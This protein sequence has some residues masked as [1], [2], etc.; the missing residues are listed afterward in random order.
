M[1]IFECTV[2]G[3]LARW[4]DGRFFPREHGHYSLAERLLA[5]G[6]IPQL[7]RNGYNAVM[8]PLQANVADMVRFDW[9]F[10]YLVSGFGA[11]DSQIGDWSA[12]KELVDAFHRE[13]IL[14]IPDIILV[15][16][17]RLTSCAF[18]RSDCRWPGPTAVGG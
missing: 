8:F 12:V 16:G 18:D 14:V 10:S 7:R 9:K 15:H 2:P 1:T 13:G 4:A 17:N 3:L 11:I 6:L 5:S